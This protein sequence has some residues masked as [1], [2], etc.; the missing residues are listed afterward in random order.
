MQEMAE[1]PG[2]M[3]ARNSQAPAQREARSSAEA[4]FQKYEQAIG[5]SDTIAKLTTLYTKGTVS[6]PRGNAD[7][8][9]YNKAPDKYWTSTTTPRGE[10]VQAFNGSDGWMKIGRVEPMRDTSEIKLD[11]DFYRSLKLSGRYKGARVFRKDK[12]GDRNAWVVFARIADSPF[13]DMLYFDT[14]TGLLLR[15]TTLRKTALGPLPTTVDFADYRDI[16]GVKMPFK[17]TVATPDGLQTV[18]VTE[19]KANLPIEDSRFE[20]PKTEQG[21]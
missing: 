20:M 11:S 3:A 18:N 16:N 1:H 17:V 8:E 9:Q 21:Q 5:G 12:V 14:E 6:S 15:R 2:E 7:F 10:R 19:M 13:T 4:L